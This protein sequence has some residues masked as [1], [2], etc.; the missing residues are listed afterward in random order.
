MSNTSGQFSPDLRLLLAIVVILLLATLTAYRVSSQAHAAVEQSKNELWA[1]EKLVENIG[2]SKSKSF[3][4]VDVEFGHSAEKVAAAKREARIPDRQNRVLENLSMR[5][6][7]D[8]GFSVQATNVDFDGLSM[9]QIAKFLLSVTGGENQMGVRSMSITANP[10]ATGARELWDVKLV[11]TT[12]AF[13]G[14]Q[15]K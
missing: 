12:T 13:S 3:S 2:A 1:V 15:G 9:E 11:L 4:S 8:S 10:R 5:A 14:N 7:G 6:I